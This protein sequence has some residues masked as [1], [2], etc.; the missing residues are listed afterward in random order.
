MQILVLKC[1]LAMMFALVL[2]IPYYIRQVRLADR[3]CSVTILPRETLEPTKLIVN[4]ERRFSL[5]VLGNIAW[6]YS[7]RRHHQRMN[8]VFYAANLKSG[9]FVLT[10]YSTNIRPDP[11]FNFYSN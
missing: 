11:L 6:R 1:R 2:N 7:W 9:H 3:E 5:E 8:V 4:P 10:S